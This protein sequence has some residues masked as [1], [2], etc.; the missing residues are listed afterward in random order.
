MN[1]DDMKQKF[2]YNKF[3]KVQYKYKE[4]NIYVRI[5]VRN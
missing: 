5:Q 2:A 4:L 1:Y 3:W